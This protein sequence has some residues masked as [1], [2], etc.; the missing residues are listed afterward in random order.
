MYHHPALV[1]PA[2][3]LALATCRAMPGA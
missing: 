3:P 1:T 2:L